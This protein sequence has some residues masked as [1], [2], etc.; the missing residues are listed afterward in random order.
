M[1]TAIVTV[2]SQTT[3]MQAAAYQADRNPAL[4]YLA[5]LSTSSRRTMGEALNKVA[6]LLGEGLDAATCPWALL[7]YQ[8]T[9]ALRTKLSETYSAA[10]TANR[11][12]YALRGVLKECWRLGYMSAEDYQRAIDIKPVM[13]QK[14]KQAERGRALR[15][16]ELGALIDACVDGTAKGARDAAIIAI[17]YGAGLRRAEIVALQVA[18]YDAD[19]GTVIVKAGK[20]NK[21][22]VIPLND[23]IADAINAWLEHRGPWAGALFTRIRKGDHVTIDGMTDQAVY[24]MFAYR[25]EQANVKEFS[26]HDMRRSFAGD[27]L[28]AGAD[29]S[30]VQKLMGH[31]SANTTAG[32][33]R[34]DAKAKRSAVNKLHVPFRKD[35]R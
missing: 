24:D 20:G 31:A 14:A 34:R 12:I 28:D 7:R 19:E 13:G 33:D 11:H 15:G 17:A 22:R 5:S 30:T 32:Y 21:E 25:A 4:V 16:G 35:K 26:P 10:A 2:N 18:D 8:H 29:I 27:L 6:S 1:D 23:G 3:I 9:Q